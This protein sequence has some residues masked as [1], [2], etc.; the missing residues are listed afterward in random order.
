MGMQ[1]KL[2]AA[3][4]TAAVASAAAKKEAADGNERE[5]A[6]SAV[7][8]AATRLPRRGADSSRALAVF[9]GVFLR[10]AT[11]PNPSTFSQRFAEIGGLMRP[12][13]VSYDA[14]PRANERRVHAVVC[15][16]VLHVRDAAHPAGREGR[17]VPLAPPREGIEDGALLASKVSVI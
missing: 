16:G 3:T 17:G 1:K 14:K 10:A 8:R 5:G 15:L 11:N 2:K 7:P 12:P 4:A 13:P 6:P 9:Y